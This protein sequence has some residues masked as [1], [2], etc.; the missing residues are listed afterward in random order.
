[1]PQHKERGE[2]TA[3]ARLLEIA[4]SITDDESRRIEYIEELARICDAYL[5]SSSTAEQTWQLLRQRVPNHAAAT[6]ALSE[7]SE[8]RSRWQQLERNYAQEAQAATDDVYRSSMLMRAAEMELR[9]SPEPNEEH[10]IEH[11]EQA[12]RLDATN[13]QAGRMLERLY[14]RGERWEDVA[15]VLDRMA[16]RGTEASERKG[17][18]IRLARLY[19]YRLQDGERAATAYERLLRETRSYPEAMEYLAGLYTTEKRWEELVALYEHDLAGRNIN[20]PEALGSLLQIARLHYRV[21][22]S[23]SDAEP[24]FERIRKLDPANEAMLEFFRD[25][26]RELGDESR[27]IDVL[28]GAQRAMPDGRTKAKAAVEL[29]ELAEKQTNA[30]RAIEQYRAVL[31]QDPENESAREALKR[32]LKATQ[33]FSTLVELLRQ[34]L[35]HTPAEEYE[36]RLSILREVAAVYRQY[37]RNDTALVTVL[38][39][40]VM[41]DEKLDEHDV[42]E[43]REL[44]ALYD[45]LG[46]HRELLTYQ[47]KLAE[48][49]PDLD[50]KTKL[51]RAAAR[52]WLEQFSNFQNATEAYEALLKVAPRDPE[53]MERLNELY[54]KRRAWA[55]LFD[56]LSLQVGDLSGTQ[57]VSVLWELAQLAADRLHRPEDATRLYRQ[58]LELD[59]TRVDAIDALE[60]HAERN[61]DWETLAFVLERRTELITDATQQSA[62]LQK[63]GAVYLE[64]LQD[65]AATVRTWR[66]VLALQP[67]H[68]RALRVLA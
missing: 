66:R 18:A 41:L 56:L 50:E 34:Q 9:F 48:V 52:R 68:P 19:R 30:Q 63:L 31:R 4:I 47:L 26:C 59:E 57:R 45:K 60:K 17:A 21:R 10:I 39:Q 7:Q 20:S 62:I 49:S 32:L 23:K 55:Q 12:V 46:R 64:H 6:T 27:W 16:V 35:E 58:L 67:G 8:R 36:K 42:E 44:V 14:R 65:V 25:Y 61:K 24:W 37:L 5:F 53:A 29:A 13:T 43:L 1:M 40:I 54:R 33:G 3:V 15:R 2:W 28:Q 11:L 22:E 38:H 51:Y